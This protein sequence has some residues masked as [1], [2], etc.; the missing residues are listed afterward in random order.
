[1]R[2]DADWSASIRGDPVASRTKVRVE[3]VDLDVGDV[4]ATVGPQDVDSV[5][6]VRACLI[7]IG[8]VQLARLR[9]TEGRPG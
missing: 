7:H 5:R 4:C 8:R 2:A 9:E 1:V 6:D 3:A